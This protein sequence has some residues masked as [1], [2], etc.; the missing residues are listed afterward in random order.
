MEAHRIQKEYIAVVRGEIHPPEGVIDMPIGRQ[1]GDIR[2]RQWVHGRDAVSAIT[3]YRVHSF[4]CPGQTDQR[5]ASFAL[6][7]SSFVRVF[8]ETGRLHQIRVHLAAIGHPIL[9]RSKAL[10]R[11]GGD[12]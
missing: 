3:K 4:F 11:R 8:P 9:G 12:L 1:G 10:Y 5:G 2:V 6:G 7:K